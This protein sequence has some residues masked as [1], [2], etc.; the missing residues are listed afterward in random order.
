[1]QQQLSLDDIL[2]PPTMGRIRLGSAINL[3]VRKAPHELLDDCLCEWQF[4][5]VDGEDQES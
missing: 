1:M 4:M 2:K 5:E 3:I